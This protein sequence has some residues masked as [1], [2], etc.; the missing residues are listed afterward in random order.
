MINLSFSLLKPILIVV[1]VSGY[2]S[3]F[4]FVIKQWR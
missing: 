1:F 3:R 4:S 2:T